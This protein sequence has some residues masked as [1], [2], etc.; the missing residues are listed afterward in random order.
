[1]DKN[2]LKSKIFR[3]I[4]RLA[5]QAID[6]YRMIAAGDHL[7]VGLSGGKD[8][9]ILMHVLHELQRKAPL[10]FKITGISFDPCFP[11]LDFAPLADY[12]KVNNWIYHKTAMRVKDELKA[13]ASEKRPCSLCSRLRRGALYAEAAKLGCGKIAL[14][15]HLDDI[16]VSLLIGL[17][18]GHGLTTMGPNVP[19]D[20]DSRRVIR[21]LAFVPES[22][23]REAAAEFAFPQCGDCHY[24]PYLDEN[25]DRAFFEN[26]LKQ[27]EQKIPHVRQN[28]LRSMSDVRPGYLLDPQFIDLP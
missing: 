22:L 27:L 10:E 14:G 28:M 19:S 13:Q 3:K 16:C 18:R 26:H 8:S 17:F 11:G 12:A 25:G 7:L 4:C 1:V 20:A 21:P 23:L 15:Q 24:K 9:M 5:G 2:P 6:K